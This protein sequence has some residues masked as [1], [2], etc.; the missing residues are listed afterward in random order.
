MDRPDQ[1]QADTMDGVTTRRDGGSAA[2]APAGGATTGTA[3]TTAEPPRTGLRFIELIGRGGF[4]EV[5][6]VEDAALRRTVAAKVLLDPSAG[7][8]R[9]LAE[10]RIT[11]GLQHPGI[12]PVH[13]LAVDGAGRDYFTMPVIEGRTLARVLRDR[14]DG[15]TLPRLVS[16]LVA[17]GEAVA[18]AHARGV[19]HRDLKPHNVMIGSFG[20]VFVLDW[21]IARVLAD[22]E[23]AGIRKPAAGAGELTLD[24]EVIGTPGYLSPEQARGERGAVGP[25]ADVY[26]LGVILYEIL[27]RR[28]PV[29]MRTVATAI[30]DTAAGRIRPVAAQPAGRGAPRALAAIAERAMA[31][32]PADRYPGAAEFV[33]DL[34]A[35]LEDR[36]VSACPDR[37]LDH[38]WRWMRRHRTASAATAAVL[39][40]A[41]AAAGVIGAVSSRHDA[42]RIRLAEAA[43]AA[44]EHAAAVERAERE[45][46]ANRER[47]YRLVHEGLDLLQRAGWNRVWADRAVATFDQALAIDRSIADA[48]RGRAEALMLAGREA[49][50]LAAYA[51]A[52]R[53]GTSV[54]GSEDPGILIAMA[55]ARLHHA[56]ADA[57]DLVRRAAAGSGAYAEYA[58]A[59]VPWFAGDRA[60]TVAGLRALVDGGCDLYEIHETLGNALIGLL[61]LPGGDRVDVTG[62]AY[63]IIDPVEAERRF[64]DAIR[65][66][67]AQ[68]ELHLLRAMARAMQF[69]Q[70]ID[71][72]RNIRGA[73]RDIELALALEPD[74]V[75]VHAS[76][77]SFMS[78]FPGG[79]AAVQEERAE[80]RRRWPHHPQALEA[81]AHVDGAAAVLPEVEA[82]L[83][84][85]PRSADLQ[86]LRDRLRTEMSAGGARP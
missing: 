75:Q 66:R 64:S 33:A 18:Y 40:A 2:A 43:Q 35:W 54:A 1:Q 46:L 55:R 80:L 17:V 76:R 68:A 59:M 25:P 77:L 63:G 31:L 74:S 8:E 21:G 61:P 3:A 13:A 27:T 30:A 72:D 49:D 32:D 51:E 65:L 29:D 84:A 22:G 38:A 50:A 86:R 41:V 70:S 42:E 79:E 81:L 10:A 5:Y 7:R 85:Y 11:G 82:A 19:V 48:H 69:Q 23:G 47:A 53:V 52:L 37:R 73:C 78:R 24:G 56:G 15:F 26:S 60:G 71:R 9:F 14:S 20:E 83:R 28:L 6:R 12:V 36:E 34:R 39:A 45:R 57:A 67:P 16:V 58:R 62:N 4:G 44:A